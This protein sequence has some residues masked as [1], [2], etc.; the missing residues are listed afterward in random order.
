MKLKKETAR[1]IAR[2]AI[3]SVFIYALPVLLMFLSFR[4]TGKRPWL[5]ND[6]TA[7]LTIKKTTP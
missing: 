1:Q 5:K 2:D 4:V 6:A 3:L 7:S